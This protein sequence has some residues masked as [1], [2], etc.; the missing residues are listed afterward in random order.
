MISQQGPGIDWGLRLF[1]KITQAGDKVLPILGVIY[2]S[3]LFNPPKDNV[4]KRSRSIESRLARHRTS[5][6]TSDSEIIV[7]IAELFNLVNNVPIWEKGPSVFY[8]FKLDFIRLLPPHDESLERR[9][10]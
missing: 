7:L 1:G 6:G 5:I 2:D 10:P 8:F 3:A 9:T 4:M